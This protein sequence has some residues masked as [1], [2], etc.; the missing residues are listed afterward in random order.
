MAGRGFFRWLAIVCMILLALS[1]HG[2]ALA[3]QTDE[4]DSIHLYVYIE[5]GVSL[6]K[7]TS[8][9]NFSTNALAAMEAIQPTDTPITLAVFTL[10][11]KPDDLGGVRIMPLTPMNE[12]GLETLSQVMQDIPTIKMTDK[13][14]EQM[15]AVG[16]KTAYK[17]VEKD[18]SSNKRLLIFSSDDWSSQYDR[19]LKS[20]TIPVLFARMYNAT[21]AAI[22][23]NMPW[24][25]TISQ[26][27]LSTHDVPE[28]ASKCYPFLFGEDAKIVRRYFM[29]TKDNA[30]TL[31]AYMP[32]LAA[33]KMLAYMNDVS[34]QTDKSGEPL[35]SGAYLILARASTP[36][37][38]AY[39][40]VS[41]P[42]DTSALLIDRFEP[43][44][45]RY[46]ADDATKATMQKTNTAV[47]YVC[48]IDRAEPSDLPLID[49]WQLSITA[50]HEKSG[51]SIQA[52]MPQN[53]VTG[54]YVG[55]IAF[56]TSGE[57]NI[58]FQATSSLGVSIV[59]DG[60]I[61]QVTN[62]NPEATGQNDRLNVWMNSPVPLAL[63]S[64]DLT[65]VFS[66]DDTSALRFSLDQNI[67]GIG[68]VG[69]RYLQADASL[70]NV[71]QATLTVAATDAEGLV[72]KAQI[73]VTPLDVT[74]LLQGGKASMTSAG[75]ELAK[76]A[77]LAVSGM[78]AL[79]EGGKAYLETLAAEDKMDAFLALFKGAFI[80]SRDGQTQAQLPSKPVLQEDQLVFRGEYAPL[81]VTGKIDVR[82]NVSW[83]ANAGG[84]QISSADVPVK[85]INKA[86]VCLQPKAE[87]DVVLPDVL[88]SRNPAKDYEYD[89]VYRLK[90]F[91]DTEP[92]DILTCQLA[93]F[94][95]EMTLYRQSEQSYVLTDQPVE[96]GVV[97]TQA[98]DA[99]VWDVTQP[100]PTLTIRL[101][102]HSDVSVQLQVKDND[103]AP[104]DDVIVLTGHARF[105]NEATLILIG[106]IIAAFLA[107]IAVWLIIHQATK[108]KFLDTVFEVR[109]E[110]YGGAYRLPLRAW[111]KKS[112]TLRD[113]IQYLGLPITTQ[114][115][116]RE[117][118][119][120][121]FTPARR[122]QVSLY[123]G[124][125]V[126]ASISV[127]GATI[128]PRQSKLKLS[129]EDVVALNLTGTVLYITMKG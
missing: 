13:N 108:P 29:S 82:L 67:A 40:G 10:P 94:G 52:A 62:P 128:N 78:F 121:V 111:R 77:P 17:A 109:M 79:S 129:P 18:P 115:S 112:I 69:G 92:G 27:G 2:D 90:D 57:Y 84:M 50:T 66:D 23:A 104:M 11:K 123:R 45:I 101:T 15:R 107:L 24:V 120:F 32:Q 83:D 80:V 118:S 64:I 58:T 125:G 59:G 56:P 25:Q 54:Q 12:Q 22:P 41:L 16:L 42:N 76:G 48:Q 61:V 100:S 93:A 105:E 89:H 106:T 122:K 55:E 85:I 68:I 6:L 28:W 44:L 98:K 75:R 72:G 31:P 110:Q 113:I 1:P 81:P 73:T 102:K 97:P 38:W 95:S 5:N 63:P 26:S 127:N 124:R 30:A 49:D 116:M 99:I 114:V 70:L 91:V 33:R 9:L 35:L 34:S 7:S 103:N 46:L 119:R 14:R 37:E 36:E 87:F 19:I 60:G 4:D 21:E 74:A 71:S 51:S 39:G 117:C 88:S 8:F 53:A 3:T 20:E 126:S 65:T 47:R 96:D 86:P 43:Y